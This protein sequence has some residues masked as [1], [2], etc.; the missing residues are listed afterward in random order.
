MPKN[1]EFVPA[2]CGPYSWTLANDV[3]CTLGSGQPQV[4]LSL[5]EC[6]TDDRLPA[7]MTALRGDSLLAYVVETV[8]AW[9]IM[10]PD[11]TMQTLSA[12]VRREIL[13]TRRQ[14]ACEPAQLCTAGYEGRT[15]DAVFSSLV[16]NNVRTLADV[17]SNP[18]SNRHGFDA[19]SLGRI[20]SLCGITYLGMPDMG[21]PYAERCGLAAGSDR[22]G[23]FRRYMESLPAK[24][25]RTE[26]IAASLQAGSAVLMCFERDPDSCHRKV[27]QQYIAE[28]YGV[29]AGP[30]L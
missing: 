15:V 14:M 8:P 19:D 16:R 5:F 6:M 27:L 21:I 2:I 22:S 4:Q 1:D 10:L 7:G 28:A 3:Q 11:S 29:P 25:S 24:H 12:S 17:R 23:L 30:E 13:K 20:S 9:G 18:D 26:Q